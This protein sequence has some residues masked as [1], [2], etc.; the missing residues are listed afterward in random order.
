MAKLRL[1][2]FEV[3]D[4][5][6][7][8]LNRGESVNAVSGHV[9]YIRPRQCLVYRPGKKGSEIFLD[10]ATFPI[11]YNLSSAYFLACGSGIVWS[12]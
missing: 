8:V 3:Q 1:E 4:T 5:N 11:R 2:A 9:T 7:N 12:S 10:E 6:A